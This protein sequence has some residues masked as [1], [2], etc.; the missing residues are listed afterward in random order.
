[1]GLLGEVRSASTA[2]KRC[3]LDEIKEELGDE[4]EEL[5]EAFD[6]ENVTNIAI[7][8][9]LRKRGLKVGEHAIS[10]HRRHACVCYR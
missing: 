4:G 2:K 10:R 1:M 6:D 9:V 8:E 3:R 7:Y 5:Q